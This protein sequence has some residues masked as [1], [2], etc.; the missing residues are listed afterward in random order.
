[1]SEVTITEV[2]SERIPDLEPLTRAL[3]RHHVQVDPA[4][5]GVPPRDQDGWWRIRSARYRDW[6]EDPDAFVLVAEID[7]ALVG[8][9]L[10]T[11]HDADDSHRTGDRFAELQSLLVLDDHRGEGIGSA[12]LHAVYER[13]RARGAE[14]MIIGVL[15]TNDRVR[16]LYEREGFTPW[17]VINMGKVPRA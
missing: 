4:I 9:A 16:R 14:E 5:P 10:V 13:V 11:F 6:L 7:G 1:V 2:G 8:Y 15:A 17:V 12:L 3:H